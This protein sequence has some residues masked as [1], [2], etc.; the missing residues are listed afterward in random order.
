MRLRD[1]VW[2]WRG[3]S[4]PRPVARSPRPR[5]QAAASTCA[6]LSPEE[7]SQA[8]LSAPQHPYRAVRAVQPATRSR[9]LMG[10]RDEC[11]ALVSALDGLFEHGSDATDVEL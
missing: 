1:S 6:C 11:V 10:N 9:A 4:R 7:P 5:A 8:I 3:D 2:P